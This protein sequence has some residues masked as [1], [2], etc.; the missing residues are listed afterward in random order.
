MTMIMVTFAM[1]KC[2]RQIKVRT[3]TVFLEMMAELWYNAD[4]RNFQA[5]T[6]TITAVSA[7]YGAFGAVQNDPRRAIFLLEV[8]R[9]KETHKISI[10]PPIY[11]FESMINEVNPRHGYIR[12]HHLVIHMKI[13]PV[14][15]T[16]CIGEGA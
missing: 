10:W 5:T 11:F 8:F 15:S 7:M 12:G 6:A 3:D 1:K 2:R 14:R 16:V 9:R 13:V 4:E